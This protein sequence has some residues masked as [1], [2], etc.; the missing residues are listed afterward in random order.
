MPLH[1]YKLW[2]CLILLQNRFCFL[3]VIHFLKGEISA[4]SNKLNM[5]RY[6]FLGKIV[7]PYIKQNSADAVL[8]ENNKIISV[9]SRKDILPLID[10]NTEV[11]DM[12]G[13]T[14][15]PGLIDAHNH[16]TMMGMLAFQLDLNHIL[17]RSQILKMIRHEHLILPSG[18][19]L[20][21]T[22]YEIEKFSPEQRLTSDDLE[23]VAPGRLIQI[24]DRCGHMS[25]TDEYTLQATGIPY[26]DPTPA[27]PGLPKKFSGILCG[28]TNSRLYHYFQQMVQSEKNLKLAWKWASDT[29]VQHGVTHIHALITEEDL[30]SLLAYKECLPIDLRIYAET[31]KIDL[32]KEYGLSQIGGCGRVMVDGDTGPETAAFL[33]PYLDHPETKGCLYW[34]DE[35]IKSYY[36]KAAENGMQVILHCIGDAASSQVMDAVENARKIHPNQIRN[37]IEHF[38][39]GDDALKDRVKKMGLCLSMQPNFNYLWPHD[40]YDEMLGEKRALEADPIHSLLSRSIP[41]GFGSDCPV[42]PCNPLLTI[43]S[44]VNHSNPKERISPEQALF[45]HTMGSAYLGCEE[46]IRGSITPGK[47]ADLTIME[48]DPELV[49]PNSIKDISVDMTV[50]RGKIVYSR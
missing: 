31:K 12:E 48:E 24:S 38:E 46:N 17:D 8:T 18:Q 27:C 30:P 11:I 32:A 4:S 15:L 21:G 41:V 39:F 35:E 43:Y 20:I 16:F 9:G 3:P 33:D 44:A 47:L 28:R 29:A 37:R 6:I 10:S 26:E 34:N 45:C 50:S 7:S 40:E 49:S 22:A 2:S 36:I 5:N 1:D 25:V 14:I 42:T 19:P 13:K 23:K